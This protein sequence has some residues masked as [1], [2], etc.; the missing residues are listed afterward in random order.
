MA[1]D[2][3]VHRCALPLCAKVDAAHSSLAT[4]CSIAHLALWQLH[5]FAKARLAT[6][7]L[8]PPIVYANT[9]DA[10]PAA[11]AVT[12]KAAKMADAA[13]A[14]AESKSAKRKRASC[15][16]VPA[17]QALSPRHPWLHSY[18]VL[19]LISLHSRATLILTPGYSHWRCSPI[20]LLHPSPALHPN[21]ARPE[22]ALAT[23]S[24]VCIIYIYLTLASLR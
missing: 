17:A 8:T 13:V 18:R 4:L 22:H 10:S 2:R 3:R 14:K 24:P 19:T 20:R 15:I 21:P 12:A 7:H 11:H 1:L 6:K 23:S 9:A 5:S 16:D